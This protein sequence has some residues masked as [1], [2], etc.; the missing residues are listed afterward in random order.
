MV[1]EGL[2]DYDAVK[3]GFVKGRGDVGVAKCGDKIMRRE[4]IHIA[5]DGPVASGKGAVTVGLSRRLDIPTLDTGALYR[6]V[7]VYLLD[8]H[9][10]VHDEKRVMLSLCKI[11][12]RVFATDKLTKVFLTNYDVS[13]KIRDNSVS[14]LTPIVAAY[15]CVR[16]FV[17]NKIA[18]IARQGDFILEGRD[19]GTAVL[20][21][22]K[23][24]FY[25]TASVEERAN[26]RRKELLAHGE[27]VPLVDVIIQV[28]DRD[29]KD[30]TRKMAPLRKAPDAILIDNTNMNIEQTIDTM[31]KYITI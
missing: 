21:S 18:D 1:E 16:E 11:N 19:I 29:H 7:T 28:K 14:I 8:N 2:C 15:P 12:M 17:N 27:N 20:P 30:M 13:Q 26:R 4:Y 22:A 9:I 25:L 23:Y 31:L 24:K 5:I 6:A 3:I 10:D